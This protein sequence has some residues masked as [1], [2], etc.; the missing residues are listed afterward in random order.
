MTVR[1]TL[2]MVCR[3]WCPGV[4]T[5]LA[6]TRLLWWRC[7]EY[8]PAMTVFINNLRLSAYHASTSLSH[9]QARLFNSLLQSGGDISW[10]VSL[11]CLM[12]SPKACRMLVHSVEVCYT[13]E[14]LSVSTLNISTWKDHSI[15]SYYPPSYLILNDHSVKYFWPFITGIQLSVIFKILNIPITEFWNW[16]INFS[17]D[18]IS[19]RKENKLCIWF[20]SWEWIRGIQYP[21]L[22][23]FKVYFSNLEQV[24]DWPRG[25]YSALRTNTNIGLCKNTREICHNFIEL[26]YVRS[27]VDAYIHICKCNLWTKKVAERRPWQPS[28]VKEDRKEPE[29]SSLALQPPA[30][31]QEGVGGT[32]LVW[33]SEQKM[34][35]M[36]AIIYTSYE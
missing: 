2:Y 19:G 35:I 4:V 24:R 9:T 13:T 20:P 23:V 15:I 8:S 21:P 5:C 27:S 16:T 29:I 7:V 10:F 22:T 28:K 30:V 33:N 11:S 14:R 34:E 32:K 17:S 25:P 36:L 3:W 31:L 6:N 12:I 18:W 26:S 1:E